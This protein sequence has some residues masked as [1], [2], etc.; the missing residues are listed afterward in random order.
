MSASLFIR[1]QFKDI[2]DAGFPYLRELAAG[3]FAAIIC[4]NPAQNRLNLP[5]RNQ[6][7]ISDSSL[8]SRIQVRS[9][10]EP[11]TSAIHQWKTRVEAHHA[12]SI[13]VQEN[14]AWES[15]DLW[16]PLMSNFKVAPVVAIRIPSHFLGEI[17][18]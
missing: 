11:M 15:G 9:R 10:T 7:H 18:S 2:D 8:Q 14:S 3:L 17:C 6:N 4:R 12:Q 13:K 5:Y 1:R 16:R